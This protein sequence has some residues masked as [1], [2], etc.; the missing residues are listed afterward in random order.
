MKYNKITLFVVALGLSVVSFAQSLNVPAAS[1]TQ[2]LKQGFGTSDIS[3]DY[4]R[5]S[6]NGRVVF[7][8]V[9]PFDKMW[10]TGAN[11]STKITFGSD[12]KVE[13]KDVKAGTYAIYSV[14]GKDS[15]D[16][17]LYK[18]L[19]I[20]GNVAK[21]KTEDEVVRVKVKPSK[22]SE[23]VESFTVNFNGFTPT[24]TSLEMVWENTKVALAITTD[25]DVTVMKNIEKYI[26]ND[27]R[28]FYSAATYY[29]D[30]N[31][32]QNLAMEWVNKALAMN[33][34]GYWMHLLKAKIAKKLNDKAT[35]T[36][37]ATECNKLATEDKDDAYI[38]MSTDFLA[39]LKK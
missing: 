1:P 5:P 14:P 25:I 18:D 21:Y 4:S 29:Y 27:S 12:V 16:V 39:E 8:N 34:K 17:M 37:A 36:A 38:K 28:P 9:V 26:I 2:T 11:S 7:G 33:P 13:G 3:L 15:W 24:S 23:K 32:D 31:K 10:R 35:A 6:A 30:N 22:V 19:T 20:G